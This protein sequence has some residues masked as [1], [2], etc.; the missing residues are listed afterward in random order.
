MLDGGE[1]PLFIA[2][3]LCL[4]ASEDLGLPTPTA[5]LLAEATFRVVHEIGMPE[6][7]IP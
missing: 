1:D 4:S 7:R 6:A 3:R 2:R 5:L